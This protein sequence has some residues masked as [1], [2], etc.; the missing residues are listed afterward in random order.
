MCVIDNNSVCAVGEYGTILK[1]HDRGNTW[2]IIDIGSQYSLTNVFF[3]NDEKGWCL[4]NPF[5][6]NKLI[7]KTDDG[8]NTW[9]E[10]VYT[11]EPDFCVIEKI[12]FTS[13]NNG[14]GIGYGRIFQ[15][16]DGGYT[17]YTLHDYWG[18]LEDICFTNSN[19]G[20]VVGYR[21]ILKTVNAG[22]TWE[23]VELWSNYYKSMCFI[24]ENHGWITDRSRGI[25]STTD[26]GNNWERYYCGDVF[27][28][29]TFSDSYNGWGIANDDG[30]LYGGF[31]IYNTT[32]GGESWE[33]QYTN[34]SYPEMNSI[35]FLDNETGWAVGDYGGLMGTSD[36]GNEWIEVSK[37]PRC[38]FQDVTFL[39]SNKGW[40]VGEEQV[41]TTND[42]G[43][44]WIRQYHGNSTEYFRGTFFTDFNH[45]WAVG[46]V[47][48]SSNGKFGALLTTVDGGY[49][50]EILLYS[51]TEN[52]NDIYLIN[53]NI[54]WMVGN[55]GIVFKTTDGVDWSSIGSSGTTYNLRSVYFLDP[56]KGWIVGDN[57]KILYSNNGGASWQSQNSGTNS[58][59]IDVYFID[60][61]VGWIVG[62]DGIILHTDNG[63]S[64]W[65]NQVSS[66]T[67]D[68]IKLYFSSSTKGWVV[69][70]T[71]I[72]IHTTNGATWT[73]QESGTQNSLRG[74]N[75]IDEYI[76]LIVGIK[77]TVLHTNNGGV[78]SGYD[79]SF[80][81]LNNMEEARF[82]AGY[83]SDESNLYSVGGLT[84]EFPYKSTT[85]ERYNLSDKEWTVIASDMIPRGYCSA[86]YIESQNSIYI[87][88]GE[89]YSNN[90]YT[91]TIEIVNVHSGTV[92]Y[93][94]SNPYPVEYCGSAVWNDKIYVFGGSNSGEYSNRLYEYNPGTNLWNRLPDMPESKQTNGVVIDGVLYV[95]GGYNQEVS[96]RIDAYDIQNSSWTYLDDLP[97]GISAHSMV[98]SGMDIWIIGSY[99][100]IHFVAI[101]NVETG[102][103]TQLCSNIIGRRHCGVGIDNNYLY[104]YGGNQGSF[105]GSILNSLQS[106]DISSYVHTIGESRSSEL[107]LISNYP[108]PFTSST[109]I[110]Y[111]L[112]EPSHVQLTIYNSI[113]VLVHESEDLY[114]PQGKHSFTWTAN[115]LPMGVYY[116][117]LRSEEQ[118]GV[119]KIVKQK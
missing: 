63:G 101:Y 74:I 60:E 112:H 111:E 107:D 51:V 97:E 49:N 89:T 76:G 19:V 52:W 81:S 95:I 13:E 96:T 71:G 105:S 57:G 62:Y 31:Y 56:N 36:G 106:A 18:D 55:G 84:D 44:N 10:I 43:N 39:N 4:E 47:D 59:L 6:T 85:V 61:T 14:W 79:L 91:D 25:Y 65:T 82:G 23:E 88:N 77:G 48:L 104:V 15:T 70:N 75:F 67:K 90:S 22:N 114:L 94:E 41:Y 21:K 113:G 54:G 72:I 37:G 38:S 99:N 115:Q 30:L 110:E 42:G 12:W 11:I 100:N 58:N 8:G 3:L 7:Y 29:M 118:V 50:W 98:T 2:N 46:S 103:F 53:S 117:I 68:L 32:D 5:Y 64:T 86:E 26:G 83:T 78:G 92:S 35:C 80:S 87:F 24:D 102:I 66:T 119:A 9:N 28:D 34:Y 27:L 45:G 16:T 33:R 73:T 40:A 108:N 109:T 1:S 20:W 17:W 69:G 93:S 116:A